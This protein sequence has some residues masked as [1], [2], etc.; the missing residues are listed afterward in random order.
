MSKVLV[1]LERN[2]P[3][4]VNLPFESE[5]LDDHVVGILLVEYYRGSCKID[6][7]FERRAE[8]RCK[9]LSSEKAV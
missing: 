7:F 8:K 5:Q 3:D 4:I 1:P 9:V 2:I 6:P